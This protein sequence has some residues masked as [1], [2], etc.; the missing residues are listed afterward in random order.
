MQTAIN[1]ALAQ[2]KA[3]GEF[4]GAD[5]QPGK[6]G[7]NGAPG[8]DGKSAYQY[9]VE[10]GYTGTEAEFA[11][12]LAEELP[13]TLPNPNA[14]TFTGAV[15][16]TYD[17]SAAVTVDIPSGGGG[18]TGGGETWE[19]ILNATADGDTISYVNNGYA[20]TEI[21]AY[22]VIK[23]GFANGQNIYFTSGS[24]GTIYEEP[25]I[26]ATVASGWTGQIKLSKKII[27]TGLIESEIVLSNYAN[28]LDVSGAKE[29]KTLIKYGTNYSTP[30]SLESFSGHTIITQSGEAF[31]AGTI[32]FV[33][34]R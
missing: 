5:G 34:G 15:S 2:A 19:T 25:R 8:A 14:L 24:K 33:R 18:T 26:Y 28:P 30:F 13:D 9:A 3:S 7:A 11:A 32:I 6:N 21:E 1:T 4:D 22:I 16:G 10:G 31:P 27:S 12:K 23:T 29:S 17:G 20:Y